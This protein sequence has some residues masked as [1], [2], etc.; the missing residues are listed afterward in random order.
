MTEL[1]DIIATIQLLAA[2]AMTQLME[3]MA[4]IKQFS[5]EIAVITQSTFQIHPLH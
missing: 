5:Q 2:Q 3:E 1:L 4:P